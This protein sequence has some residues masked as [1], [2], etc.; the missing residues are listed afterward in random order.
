MVTNSITHT[1]GHYGKP[2]IYPL[3]SSLFDEMTLSKIR[4]PTLSQIL[5]S[6][7]SRTPQIRTIK[8]NHY[9]SEH[10]QNKTYIKVKIQR[11]SLA[12]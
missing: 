2:P 6:E 3:R 8:F 9:T 10:Y 1:W 7:H 5:Q 4:T 11:Y 12:S